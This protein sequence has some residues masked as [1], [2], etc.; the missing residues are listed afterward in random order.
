MFALSLERSAESDRALT[1]LPLCATAIEPW[2]PSTR[3]GCAFV[4]RLL[5]VVE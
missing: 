3:M 5:P 2:G 4:S 1:M